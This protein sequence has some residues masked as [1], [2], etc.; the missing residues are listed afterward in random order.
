V[1]DAIWNRDGNQ[2][3]FTDG[4][5]LF[6]INASGSDEKRL[7]KPEGHWK[8][9]ANLTL[10]PDGEKLFFSNGFRVY[11]I[12]LGDSS[13]AE[14]FKFNTGIYALEA[15]PASE[16][17]VCVVGDIEAFQLMVLDTNTRKRKA[18][19]EW[20]VLGADLVAP[21]VSPNGQF[22]L[23]CLKESNGNYQ[24]HVVDIEGKKLRKITKD[25]DNNYPYF[26]R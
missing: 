8:N 5:D 4:K 23:F 24:I 16:K 22:V 21:S 14:L 15:V 11:S 3:Y 2:I 18:L 9:K 1:E 20:S 7:P 17:L 13:Y 19:K 6:S 26:L 10:A 12:D 25:G